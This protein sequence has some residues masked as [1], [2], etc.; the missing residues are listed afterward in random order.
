MQLW[1]YSDPRRQPHAKDLVRSALMR[2]TQ[3]QQHTM[4][5]GISFVSG[6]GMTRGLIGC[7]GMALLTKLHRTPLNSVYNTVLTCLEL[8]LRVILMMSTRPSTLPPAHSQH[9]TRDQRLQVQTLRL[10]GHTYQYIANL[11]HITERQV[12]W[13][14]TSN[15]VTPKHRAGRPRTLTEAQIDELEAYIR[16]SRPTRQMSYRRLAFGPF[17]AWGVTEHVIRR[18]LQRRG[19]ARR[20]ARAKPP[21][22]NR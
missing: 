8:H 13:A 21:L 14:A 1:Q 17:E 18:A 15:Q 6:P 3:Q 7:S 12:A 11:L 20:V 22:N 9:L 10:A 5:A 19:Y 2:S 4:V 16:S